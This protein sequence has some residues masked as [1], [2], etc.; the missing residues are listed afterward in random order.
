MGTLA[1]RVLVWRADVQG[2]PTDA[3]SSGR[4]RMQPCVCT[5]AA[6]RR[7]STDFEQT[8]EPASPHK[9]LVA[10]DRFWCKEKEYSTES[11]IC[12]IRYNILRHEQLMS[13][14]S[15]GAP[16]LGIP[17]VCVVVLLRLRVFMPWQ[18]PTATY[19]LYST[20]KSMRLLAHRASKVR[21]RRGCRGRCSFISDASA[22]GEAQTCSTCFYIRG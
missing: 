17:L 16:A 14:G 9:V 12:A 3:V 7:A 5:Y 20:D 2:R 22:M 4:V 6:S 21:T 18:K 1:W 15:I 19:G 13:G 8:P 11:R 10:G